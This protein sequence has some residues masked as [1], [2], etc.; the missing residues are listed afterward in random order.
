MLYY[1]LGSKLGGGFMR[2]IRRGWRSAAAAALVAMLAST[3][4]AAAPA[5]LTDQQLQILR[6]AT[7]SAHYLT[8]ASFAVRS[9]APSSWIAR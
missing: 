9:R 5:K 4:Q 2:Y 1:G 6:I 7:A 3:A 8:Q